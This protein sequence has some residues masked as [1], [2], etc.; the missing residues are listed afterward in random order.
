MND[1]YQSK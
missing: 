1:Y